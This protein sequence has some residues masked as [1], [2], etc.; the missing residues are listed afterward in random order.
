ME[1]KVGRVSQEKSCREIPSAWELG[2]IRQAL[3]KKIADCERARDA[4]H[5]P[6]FAAIWE[7][8]AAAFR[9]RRKRLPS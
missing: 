9:I 4:A 6:Q 1:D 5:D 2:K 7:T 8:H 3:G